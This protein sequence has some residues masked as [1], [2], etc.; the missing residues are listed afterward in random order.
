MPPH[1]RLVTRH[2][3]LTYALKHWPAWQQRILAGIVRVEARRRQTVARLKGDAVTAE[4]FGEL[5]KIAADLGRGRQ[6][7][8]GRRL[9]RV[10]RRQ[11]KRCAASP[12]RGGSQS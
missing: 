2:A 1:L 3:L 6:G 12:V 9:R 4:V 8:A 11:E 10:I 5:D 7:A